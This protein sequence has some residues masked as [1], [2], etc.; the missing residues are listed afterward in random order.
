MGVVF[1]SPNVLRTPKLVFGDWW[2]RHDGE[3]DYYC[4]YMI[5]VADDDV[6]IHVEV[7]DSKRTIWKETTGEWG[8]CCS[9]AGWIR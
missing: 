8:M 5:C 3:W 2:N 4:E 1:A 9:F 7:S 6:K